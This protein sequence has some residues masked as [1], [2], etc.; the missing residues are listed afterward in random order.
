MT[1]P[2]PIYTTAYG[3]KTYC[4]TGEASRLM[5]RGNAPQFPA[6]IYAMNTMPTIRDR[7][8]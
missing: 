8:T 5:R 7:V 4:E 2:P 1:T 3:A 6:H